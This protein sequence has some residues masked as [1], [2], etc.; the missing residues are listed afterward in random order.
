V[1]RISSGWDLTVRAMIIVKS[2][3]AAETIAS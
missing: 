3:M 1:M 2:A